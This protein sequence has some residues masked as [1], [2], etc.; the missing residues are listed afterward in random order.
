M[1]G[2]KVERNVYVPARD[3]VRL[4]V[5]IYRPDAPGRFPALLALSPYGKDA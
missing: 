5:D 4:A 3:G 1:Y 2:T